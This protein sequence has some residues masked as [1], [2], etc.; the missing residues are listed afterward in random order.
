MTL[1]RYCYKLK[2]SN[3][4]R[5]RTLIIVFMVIVFYYSRCKI[6]IN[7]NSLLFFLFGQPLIIIKYNSQQTIDH[8]MV[9]LNEMIKWDGKYL[10]IL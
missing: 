10:Y 1:S 3:I 8:K 4:I 9:T 7:I 2:F 6:I 5:N